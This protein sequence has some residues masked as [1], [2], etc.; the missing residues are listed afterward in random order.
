MNLNLA[1]DVF[2]AEVRKSLNRAID[3][4]DEGIMMKDPNTVYRPSK[5]RK[6]GW[7]KIKPEVRHFDILSVA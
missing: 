6:G 7:W 1:L 2:R 4:R 3:N 5:E